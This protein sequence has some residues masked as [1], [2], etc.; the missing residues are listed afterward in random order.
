M[1]MCRYLEETRRQFMSLLAL[2]R[3]QKSRAAVTSQCEVVSLLA[4]AGV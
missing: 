4:I 1:G 3:W 2:I